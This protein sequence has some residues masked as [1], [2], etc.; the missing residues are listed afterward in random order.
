MPYG[1][2]ALFKIKLDFNHSPQSKILLEEML[3][4]EIDLLVEFSAE[5]NGRQPKSSEE[6]KNYLISK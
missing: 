2:T 1:T 3:S 5:C 4:L 6:R